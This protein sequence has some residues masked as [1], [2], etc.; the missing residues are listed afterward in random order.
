MEAQS[1]NKTKYKKLLIFT[2]TIVISVAGILWFL[3]YNISLMF[4]ESLTVEKNTYAYRLLITDS[5]KALPIHKP[6]AA[7]VRYHYS[8][9]DGPKPGSDSLE[10]DTFVNKEQILKAYRD[11]FLSQGYERLQPPPYAEESIDYGNDQESFNVD[12]REMQGRSEV[13]IYHL[14]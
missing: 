4:E 3:W 7:S 5:V 9:G 6:I 10:Y 12:V 14:Q 11:Y 8:V 1:K 13:V 2:A